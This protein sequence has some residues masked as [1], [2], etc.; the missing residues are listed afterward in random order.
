MSFLAAD[1]SLSQLEEEEDGDRFCHWPFSTA[2]S[3]LKKR[4]EKSET[5]VNSQYFH[6]SSTSIAQRVSLV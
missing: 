4:K 6:R 5:E 1:V 2:C 3:V